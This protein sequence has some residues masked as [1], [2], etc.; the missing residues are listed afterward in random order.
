MEKHLLL[1]SLDFNKVFSTV[2]KSIINIKFTYLV[3]K[4]N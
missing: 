4:K 2:K 1:K 3:G